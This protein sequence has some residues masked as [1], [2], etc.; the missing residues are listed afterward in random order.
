MTERSDLSPEQQAV[1]ELVLARGRTPEEIA[2][3]LG[4]PADHVEALAREAAEKLG[5]GP[6]AQAQEIHA[7]EDDDAEAKREHAEANRRTRPMFALYLLVIAV[8]LAWAITQGFVRQDDDP[9][10]TGTVERFAGAIEAKDGQAACAELTEDART[11]LESQEKK[12]CDEAILGL[13]LSGG[14]VVRS[15]VVDTS[16]AVS[17]DQGERAYLDKTSQ[18]WKISAAG[19]KPQPGQPDECELE[20]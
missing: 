7:G 10:A 2:E 12:P 13:G 5:F 16:A 19:C 20:S 15:D 1:V 8:G 18:G 3:T 17:L 14:D 6:G 11:A 4:L 9:A